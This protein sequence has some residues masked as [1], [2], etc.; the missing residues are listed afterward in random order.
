[1]LTRIK[2]YLSEKEV[3]RF[4]ISL[5]PLLQERNTNNQ[6]KLWN[7]TLINPYMSCLVGKPTMWFP[8]RSD[9]NRPVQ[10]QKRARSLKFR[11]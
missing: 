5:K 1:M 4:E 7:K 3:P 9:T 11:I 6:T 10:A 2:G 8:T